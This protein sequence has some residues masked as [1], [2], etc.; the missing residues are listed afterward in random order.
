MGYKDNVTFAIRSLLMYRKLKEIGIFKE[1]QFTLAT[2]TLLNVLST[3]LRGKKVIIKRDLLKE[4]KFPKFNK[5]TTS[6]D[7]YLRGIKEALANKTEGKQGN[8]ICVNEKR[9][10]DRIVVHTRKDSPKITMNIE[11]L[12]EI[13]KNLESVIAA[14]PNYSKDYKTEEKS[15]KTKITRRAR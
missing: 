9:V 5:N 14:D 10:I 3:V 8:F 4:K 15:F 2:G 11:N 1:Y 7:I 12:E 13:L 6:I